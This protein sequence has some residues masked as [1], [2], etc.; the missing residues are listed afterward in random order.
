MRTQTKR[1][2]GVASAALACALG[3]A[4]AADKAT[5]KAVKEGEA[6]FNEGWPAQDNE[7]NWSHERRVAVEAIVAEEDP[8]A[9]E[10]YLKYVL[11]PD[12]PLKADWYVR[13]AAWKGLSRALGGKYAK[14]ARALVDK[15]V[16]A[17]PKKTTPTLRADL[18][19]AMAR[20]TDQKKLDFV[21]SFMADESEVVRRSV[22]WALTGMA[23]DDAVLT[24]L[25]LTMWEKEKDPFTRLGL[26]VHKY[27]VQVAGEDKGELPKDWRE[28]LAKQKADADAKKDAAEGKPPTT[29]ERDPNAPLPSPPEEQH[30]TVSKGLEKGIDYKVRGQGV[31][32]L[33]L[34]DYEYRADFIEP[35]LKPLEKVCRVVLVRLPT[36][37]DFDEKEL[38]KFE[39]T[40]LYYYPVDR[41]VEAFEKIREELQIEKFTVCA[42][43]CTVPTVAEKYMTK[44]TNHVAKMILVGAVSGDAV[45]SNII[46]K[47]QGMSK[48]KHD[49][50]LY[51][52]MRYWQIYPDGHYDYTPKTDEEK[53]SL[54]RRYFSTHF[55][56]STDPALED[57]Y[58]S[59]NAQPFPE[60]VYPDFQLTMQGKTDG[61][62]L[63]Q[64]GRNNVWQDDADAEHIRDW[65]PNGRVT[66]YDQ[67]GIYPMIEEP[68]KWI[69]EMRDFC[70][71]EGKPKKK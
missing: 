32:L 69:A 50:E 31:P 70:A 6:K 55:H 18:V 43:G 38:K 46:D 59:A 25:I 47:Q 71:G 28:W 51:K 66:F 35:W 15:V 44:F 65:Y 58:D 57:L 45:Y 61:P 52:L 49:D 10:I 41:L 62:V 36:V 34:N 8:K 22:A 13:A 63:V 16:K 11:V 24:E 19:R 30:H 12:N 5:E 14:E 39:K 9:A 7:L 53:Q 3:S 48:T 26:E 2:L 68:A 67:S 4:A 60:I 64:H 40:K 23:L 54:L 37:T 1:L 42:F 20:S 33:V 29:R 27:L 17:G 56:D 21:K